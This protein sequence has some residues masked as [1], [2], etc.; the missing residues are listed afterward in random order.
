MFVVPALAGI[1]A[2]TRLKAGLRTRIKFDRQ[3]KRAYI[4]LLPKKG[5]S[6][7]SASKISAKAPAGGH[8]PGCPKTLT[9]KGSL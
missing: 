9:E 2:T 8:D 3:T 5:A 4:P 6:T 7:K 1:R